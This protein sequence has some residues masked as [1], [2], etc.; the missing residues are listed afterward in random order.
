MAS[1]TLSAGYSAYLKVVSLY[2]T[3]NMYQELDW[4]LSQLQA[5]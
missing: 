2:S 4:S 3:L 5:T 1:A